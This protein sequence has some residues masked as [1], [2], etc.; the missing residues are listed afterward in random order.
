MSNTV[1]HSRIQSPPYREQ[2]SCEGKGNSFPHTNIRGTG[3]GREDRKPTLLP[4][5]LGALARLAPAKPHHEI[6]SFLLMQSL[7]SHQ[8]LDILT[9]GVGQ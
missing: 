4:Q 5:Q 8:L 7:A 1:L 9:V 2:F 3:G 6:G